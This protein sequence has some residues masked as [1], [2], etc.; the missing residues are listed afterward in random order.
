LPL[1]VLAPLGCHSAAP[2]APRAR[3]GTASPRALKRVDIV[4]D[5][6]SPPIAFGLRCAMRQDAKQT[7]TLLE[8]D[9][10]RVLVVLPGVGWR[11][12]I[13]PGTGL[14]DAYREHGREGGGEGENISVRL[15]E[16]RPRFSKE[17]PEQR[18]RTRIHWDGTTSFFIWSK[19]EVSWTPDGHPVLL[20]TG[21]TNPKGQTELFGGIVTTRRRTDGCYLDYVVTH[22]ELPGAADV[23]P[24]WKEGR[25]PRYL[26]AEIRDFAANFWLADDSGNVV[27]YE[28]QATVTGVG[29]CPNAE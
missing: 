1:L 17:Q 5:F 10:A 29:I 23:G 21:I 18:V 8:C 24:I 2:K 3:P 11:S 22:T 13:P 28:A 14:I 6:T 25:Q 19:P 20:M 9:D 4:R 16:S 12:F 7:R 26:L 15:T 27:S